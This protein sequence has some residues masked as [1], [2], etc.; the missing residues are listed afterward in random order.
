MKKIRLIVHCPN[1]DQTI[2]IMGV[3]QAMLADLNT[4]AESGDV[5]LGFDYKDYYHF[6]WSDSTRSEIVALKKS[7][8]AEGV[9]SKAT[10]SLFL[11]WSTPWSLLINVCRAVWRGERVV[12]PTW[13]FFS[14]QQYE[15]SWERGRVPLFVKR[16]YLR[17]MKWFFSKVASHYYT[18]GDADIEHSN[19]PEEK[20][21][22]GTMGVPISPVLSYDGDLS[23]VQRT[24]HIIY[25]GRGSWEKKGI[26]NII[27]YG[28]SEAGCGE[29]FKF[30]V[31]SP[32]KGFR[33]RIEAMN[34]PRERFFFDYE[35]RGSDL[36]NSWA[37][38]KAL[39]T[40]NQNPIPVRT[41]YES[42]S[43]GVPVIVYREGCMDMFQKVLSRV[44][45]EDA[46][47]IVSQG[48][49][50]NGVVHPKGL[51]PDE[52]ARLRKV[53]KSL[54]DP[55]VHA[56]WLSSWISDESSNSDYLSFAEESL[57]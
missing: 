45:I 47:Q 50:M 51:T 36:V 19:L 13:G 53:S 31:S 26:K 10:C 39:V 37:G 30:Y 52:S 49:L 27:D 54:F 22:K 55:E 38:A 41:A 14:S 48:D 21:V 12:I 6:T 28:L 24:G 43:L 3:Y 4:S 34:L 16:A 5:Y 40:L 11:P 33:E 25:V 46:V 29:V 18:F 7:P 56:K 15:T 1:I 23:Q 2:G 42:L 32:E 57:D 9:R 44:G 17:T 8:R 35:S 20:C